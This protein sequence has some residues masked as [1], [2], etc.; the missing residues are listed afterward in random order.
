MCDGYMVDAGDGVMR[1]YLQA[2]RDIVNPSRGEKKADMAP[3]PAWFL[4]SGLIATV[5][6]HSAEVSRLTAENEKARGLLERADQ[7]LVAA[8]ASEKLRIRH[9]RA[10][11]RLCK[12]IRTELDDS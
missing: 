7:L 9:E 1:D 3:R 4:L 6:D 11:M 12:K 2:A 8:T 5:D 10:A